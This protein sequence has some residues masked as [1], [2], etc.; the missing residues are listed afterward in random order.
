[1]KKR[2]FFLLFLPLVLYG[3]SGVYHSWDGI[4]LKPDAK[5][6]TLNLFI[7]IIYDV[8][9]GDD[10]L[11]GDR[12]SCWP[13]AFT[14]GINNEAVPSYL[15]NFTFLDTG[16][17]RNHLRGC[18]TR[19][20][21]ESSFN[22][23]QLTGDFTVI[24]LKESRILAFTDGYFDVDGILA[25]ALDYLNVRGLRTLYGHDRAEDYGIVDGRSDA[26]LIQV[27]F[28]NIT[29]NNGGL[30]SGQGYSRDAGAFGPLKIG[31]KTYTVI[32]KS[33]LQCVG[34]TDIGIN[35]TGIVCHEVSH[36]LFGSNAFH[37]SGGN[38]RG[39]SEQMPFLT[40]QGGYG[41][42]GCANSSLVCCN[43]YERWRM[44]WKHPSAPDY[45]TAR[46]SADNTFLSSDVSHADGNRTFR[47]RDFITTGDAVR[48]RLPYKGSEACSNQYIWLENHQIG[49]NG[50][51][52]YLQYSND[53]TCRPQG[54]SGIY[55]YYQVGRDV[56]TGSRGAVWFKDER[57][58]LRQIPA[59][60]YYNYRYERMAA[61][62]TYN[63]SCVNYAEHD[64]FHVREA[65]NPFNG[66]SDLELQFH[67]GADDSVLTRACEQVIWRKVV[68]GRNND[69][70][71]FLG[72][73]RDA[74]FTSRHL[75]MGTNP[76]TCNARTYYNSLFENGRS[77]Y[78]VNRNN[79]R[80]ER[81]TWLSGLGITM[82]PQPDGD[83]IVRIRWD[84]Y[85]I[86]NDANWTG[87]I[88]LREKA[89]LTRG[90]CILLTRNLTPEQPYR[91][92]NS[93]CFAPAS[94]LFCA[95]TSTFVLQPK[96]RLVLEKQSRVQLEDGCT[97][98]MEEGAEVRIGTGCVFEAGPG[99]GLHLDR[100][101]RITVEA[102]GELRL[103]GLSR[104]LRKAH[105]RVLPGGKLI[106][107]EVSHQPD[108]RKRS[109]GTGLGRKSTKE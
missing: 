49:S 59:E 12:R 72:D 100:N 50:K 29:W 104:I 2:I 92:K 3:Q 88:V 42:M 69:S 47:L 10:P 19:L 107:G 37:T 75:N 71:A 14:E 109:S 30:S 61:G 70:L 51:L 98:V 58:N 102:G 84:D 64:G 32:G 35:P 7:N 93:G 26:S 31:K 68:D 95:D 66:Y 24:N 60:G 21:G 25:T 85:D 18:M 53:F 28:R 99:A 44:H 67:P 81:T 45:I 15:R 20:Y 33:T 54:T 97:F 106:T 89:V 105:I 8:Y 27:F 78:A 94:L 76:S 62:Q 55:A 91:D 83:F 101:A 77:D 57:D 4:S 38:H 16:Y 36:M 87:R 40:L 13:S 41:L 86:C 39:S 80:N 108:R 46:D 103:P 90:H 11:S 1:M 63:L 56:L 23:L 74:F 96:S 65:E 43:A 52:D 82:E 34:N 48:I 5:I 6:R 73:G 9:P 79:P 22:A 17:N